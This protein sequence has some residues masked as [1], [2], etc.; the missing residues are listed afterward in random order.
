MTIR[1]HR[2][3]SSLG[4]KILAIR[5]GDYKNFFMEGEGKH[6][7]GYGKDTGRKFSFSRFFHKS[8]KDIHFFSSQKSLNCLMFLLHQEGGSPGKISFSAIVGIKSCLREGTCVLEGQPMGI[9]PPSSSPCPPM[10]MTQ[11]VKSVGGPFLC[12]C[13]SLLKID[14]S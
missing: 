11:R 3:K 5:K 8:N 1:G 12:R 2:S 13:S 10:N 9:P 7:L 14:G 6:F 4:D